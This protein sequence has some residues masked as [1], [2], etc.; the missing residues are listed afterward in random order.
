MQEDQKCYI[1][2][3]QCVI[4]YIGDLDSIICSRCGKYIINE[5]VSSMIKSESYSKRARAIASSALRTGR[6]PSQLSSKNIAQLFS[7]PDMP[8]SAKIDF[9]LEKIAQNTETL[10]QYVIIEPQNLELQAISWCIDADELKAM[11][12]MLSNLGRIEKKTWLDSSSDVS[13]SYDGWLHLEKINATAAST[14][15]GF[16]AM[17]F[18]AS[19]DSVFSQA[20]APGISD[21]GYE[22]LRIDQKDHNDKIDDEIM[23]QIRKSRFLVADA[24]GS[25]GGVYYEAGFAHGLG[26][27]VFWTCRQD[28]A[29]HFDVRQYNCIFWTDDNLEG[30]RKA[31]ANRIGAVLGDGPLLRI[32]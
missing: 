13:I 17:W 20:I 25:R 29:L 30:F 16:V 4:K 26:L 11:I 22:P 31:L 28:D 21:A 23:R 3:N 27:P 6:F 24:T 8:I 5:F 12:K 9:L 18:D 32:R 1:C 7:L 14:T 10:G 2:H 15:Q 19:M